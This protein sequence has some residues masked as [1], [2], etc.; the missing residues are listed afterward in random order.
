MT[1]DCIGELP[2]YN[3]DETR[4][5][6]TE[7]TLFQ[8]DPAREIIVFPSTMTSIQRRKIHTLAHH[9]GL[10][11]RSMG[12][13]ANRQLH[14]I[15]DIGVSP[16]ATT[17]IQPPTGVSLDLH[18]RGLSRAATID[19]AETR[20]P[21]NQFGT[22][23]GRSGVRPM[24]EL[25]DNT[26]LGLNGP[27]RGVKS[28]ADLRS[29]TPSPSPSVGYVQNNARLGNAIVHFGEYSNSIKGQTNTLNTP[30]TPGAAAGGDTSILIPS[31]GS[32]SLADSFPPTTQHRPQPTPG[33]IG[34]QRPGMSGVTNRTAPERQP[35]GPISGD[36][37][38]FAS[39]WRGRQNGHIQRDSG[40]SRSQT[41]ERKILVADAPSLRFVG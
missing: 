20:N 39:G 19:F 32:M 3:D 7:L 25:P 22:T 10:Q 18:R 4:R 23:V 34:S 24:L 35:I 36:R 28:F 41:C 21:P 8:S 26:D 40:R 15:K 6:F 31:I 37:G 14:V 38:D 30:T 27:L 5:F 29:F 33:A 13:G 2:D 12:E 11:H 9:M 16:S 1:D 17:S